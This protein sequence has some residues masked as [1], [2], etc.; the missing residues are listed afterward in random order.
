MIDIDESPL[1]CNEKSV[2]TVKLK[3]SVKEKKIA[4]NF[5][6]IFYFCEILFTLIFKNH[7]YLFSL[8]KS[9]VS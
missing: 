3:S 4:R 1:D 8:S 5:L 9:S 7:F 2:K 6:F